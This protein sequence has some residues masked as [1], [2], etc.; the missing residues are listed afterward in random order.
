MSNAFILGIRRLQAVLVKVALMLGVEVHLGTSFAA[1]DA[2]GGPDGAWR[3]RTEPS[4]PN[5]ERLALDFLVGAEGKRVT[6][7]GE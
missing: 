6:V 3:V 5:V 7:P 4:L 2:P 1:L